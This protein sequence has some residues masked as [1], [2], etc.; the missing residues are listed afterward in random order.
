LNSL[1]IC[2]KGWTDD[3]S[4]GNNTE[5]VNKCNKVIDGFSNSTIIVNNNSSDNSSENNENNNSDSKIN[6]NF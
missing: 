2:Y 6:F 1:C 4:S 3:N 5:F